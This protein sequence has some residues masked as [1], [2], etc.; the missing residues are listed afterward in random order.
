[1]DMLE[2]LGKIL[3]LF[4]G[5]LIVS[6]GLLWGAGKALGT[7]RLLPGDIII[8]RPGFTF[9]FP[10]VTSIVLSVI[11]TLIFWLVVVFRR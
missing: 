4:G 3:L 8:Q 5:L 1:M 6:G 10:I 9:V 7:G 2:T 11:L